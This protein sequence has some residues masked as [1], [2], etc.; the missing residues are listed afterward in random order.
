MT[1]SDSIGC[2]TPLEPSNGWLL[3]SSNFI[4]RYFKPSVYVFS[5]SFLDSLSLSTA[6]INFADMLPKMS[7]S[8]KST[9]LASKGISGATS[10]IG[11]SNTISS[12]C[13]LICKALAIASSNVSGGA[14]IFISVAGIFTDLVWS[15]TSGLSSVPNFLSITILIST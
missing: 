11:S 4:P 7:S 1:A 12:S 15:I 2:I 14:S 8:K 10:C 13:M 3:C 9:K 6:F 5:Q